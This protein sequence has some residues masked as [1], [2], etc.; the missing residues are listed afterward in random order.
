VEL[1]HQPCAV[2]AAVSF[3]RLLHVQRNGVVRHPLP[4]AGQAVPRRSFE[5]EAWIVLRM[6]HDDD[7]RTSA[8]GEQVEAVADQLRADP[9]PLAIGQDGHGASP[10]PEI[11][12]P[13]V[14]TGVQRM[15]PT[16]RPASSATSERES[17]QACRS[18][19]TS[20]PSAVRPKAS[21]LT[22]RTAL[23]SSARSE[24]MVMRQ[25]REVLDR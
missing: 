13:G 9:L 6:S 23:A 21:S 5:P 7:E 3:A 22:R 25:V 4:L 16:T 24:Q 15:W 18:R 19:S 20:T 12:L 17:G 14:L 10:I 1:T 2:R 11:C 8:G